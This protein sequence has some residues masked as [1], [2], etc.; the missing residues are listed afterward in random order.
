MNLLSAT[1]VFAI[2]TALV[3]F[4]GH[5]SLKLKLILERGNSPVLVAQ[6]KH[7]G[8]M[9]VSDLRPEQRVDA[10]HAI[11]ASRP[12]VPSKRPIQKRLQPFSRRGSS[13]ESSASHA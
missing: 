3:S 8:E 7:E 2:V 4:F 13:R 10:L 9:L 12:A 5:D 11:A 6:Y 1:S